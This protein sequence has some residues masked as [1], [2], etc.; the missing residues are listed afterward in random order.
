[1]KTNYSNIKFISR[2][3]T[4]Y[5]TKFR[6]S[7]DVETISGR[8][9]FKKTTNETVEIFSN[10]TASF[11]KFLDSGEHVPIEVDRLLA[12]YN[13]KCDKEYRLSYL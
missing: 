4:L 6:A 1:M 8:W 5:D 9:W 13:A 7:V 11:F 3:G 12:V 2:K 10:Y